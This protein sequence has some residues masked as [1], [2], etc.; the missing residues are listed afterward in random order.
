[1]KDRTRANTDIA[2]I[3]ASVKRDLYL[4]GK[5]GLP[6]LAHLADVRPLCELPGK[7]D[8]GV[9]P[10]LG[11]GA[12]QQ[13]GGATEA[14]R[15]RESVPSPIAVLLTPILAVWMAIN[16]QTLRSPSQCRFASSRLGL[17][18]EEEEGQRACGRG[19]YRMP[20]PIGEGTEQGAE[21]MRLA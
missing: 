5:R 20:K 13:E 18:V 19:Q 4:R 10:S 15:S 14:A 6:T 2:E 9:R 16:R 17:R 11:H 8:R 7:S 21:V 12:D 3:C 1:M